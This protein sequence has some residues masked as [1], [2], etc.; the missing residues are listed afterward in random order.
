[1]MGM[2]GM[3]LAVAVTNLSEAWTMHAGYIRWLRLHHPPKTTQLSHKFTGDHTL[4]TMWLAGHW[5]FLHSSVVGDCG[6]AEGP[7]SVLP[8]NHYVGPLFCHFEGLEE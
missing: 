3:G 8:A 5:T 4:L 6:L 1:M 7:G 2:E